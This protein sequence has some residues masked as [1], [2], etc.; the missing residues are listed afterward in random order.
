MASQLPLRSRGSVTDTW[1][2]RP[3][4]AVTRVEGNTN[5]INFTTDS[6]F[7]DNSFTGVTSTGGTSYTSSISVTGV[8]STR[9]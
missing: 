4:R 1:Y 8:T 6:S 7:I 2:Y 9:Q 5:H 3:F